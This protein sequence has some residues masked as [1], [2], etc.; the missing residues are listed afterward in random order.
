MIGPTSLVSCGFHRA[1]NGMVGRNSTK[2][3]PQCN[4]CAM[5]ATAGRSGVL[6]P[7]EGRWHEDD[8]YS[9]GG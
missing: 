1:F 3:V 9:P 8:C 5:S 6:A 2:E 7:R 4:N